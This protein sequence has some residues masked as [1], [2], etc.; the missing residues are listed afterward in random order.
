[1]AIIYGVPFLQLACLYDA[2]D[3]LRGDRY[4]YGPGHATEVPGT[5]ARRATRI[6]E[7]DTHTPGTAATLPYAYASPY[8]ISDIFAPVL[9]TRV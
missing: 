3:S 2:P 7:V 1:M 8:N 6:E 5:D 4:D 9:L